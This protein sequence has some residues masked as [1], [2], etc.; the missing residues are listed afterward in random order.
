MQAA[1]AFLQPSG[2]LARAA[3]PPGDAGA[4]P[5]LAAALGAAAAADVPGGGAARLSA[6]AAAAAASVALALA[7]ARLPAHGRRPRRS[8]AITAQRATTLAEPPVAAVDSAKLEYHRKMFNDVLCVRVPRKLEVFLNVL[9]ASGFTVLGKDDWRGLG[10]L[11]P[12]MMPIATRGEGD[13]ADVVGLLL[14]TPNGQALQPDEYQVVSQKPRKTWKLVLWSLTMDKWIAKR[15]EEAK[16][17]NSEQDQ[18]VLEAVKDAYDFKFKGGDRSSLNKWL[19]L[20]VGAFPDVYRQLA[21][22]LL[23]RGDP[24]SALSVA[25]TMRDAFGT[26]WAFP[27]SYQCGILRNHYNQPDSDDPERRTDRNMEADHS[28]ERCFKTGYPLWSLAEEDDLEFLLGEAKMPRLEDMDSLRVFYLGRVVNDQRAAV[29]TGD[30]SE[31]CATLAKA[32]E[33][34]L[35]ARSACRE[36]GSKAPQ[37]V[38]NQQR[39]QRQQNTSG[40]N[41]KAQRANAWLNGPPVL[42]SQGGSRAGGRANA[43]ATELSNEGIIKLLKSRGLQAGSELD[44]ML[45]EVLKEAEGPGPADLGSKGLQDLLQRQS[46]KLK[47]IEGSTERVQNAKAALEEAQ[48]YFEQECQQLKAHQDNLSDIEKFIKKAQSATVLPEPPEQDGESDP[49]HELQM[50]DVLEL[51][52]KKYTSR[53]AIDATAVLAATEAKKAEFTSKLPKAEEPSAPQPATGADPS[54]G[55]AGGSD[56]DIIVLDPDDNELRAKLKRAGFD[57]ADDPEALRSQL[58]ADK[59]DLSCGKELPSSRIAAA[60]VN[61]GISTPLAV[62]SVY[63][64]TSVGLA[65]VNI[66]LLGKLLQAVGKLQFPWIVAAE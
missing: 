24:K 65:G 11:H 41:G 57:A 7:A 2:P 34:P 21:D 17:E 31:G 5:A 58:P 35:R 23:L 25:D 20:Q 13:D 60:M 48:R 15:A 49:K 9:Q 19:L 27:H 37:H 51:A 1:P 62:V 28:A 54:P 55:G 8:C 22:E 39:E 59:L 32:G 4:P 16:F 10:D 29:R 52:V 12:F 45:T 61:V 33:R 56:P 6:R 53:F 14:R 18:G 3:P 47:Q 30:I 50:L 38:I 36:C 46:R 66:E 40:G 43:N 44:T 64:H 63:L 42:Q 26:Q